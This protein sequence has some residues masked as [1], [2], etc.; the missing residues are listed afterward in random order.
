MAPNY[1]IFHTGFAGLTA[2]NMDTLSIDLLQG[3]IYDT[4][5]TYRN[6]DDWYTRIRQEFDHK[7]GLSR[8]PSQATY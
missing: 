4:K 3:E 1:L 5:D 7:Y 8:N 6:L 2:I